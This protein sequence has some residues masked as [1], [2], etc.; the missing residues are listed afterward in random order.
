M[1]EDDTQTS[2]EDSVI[3]AAISEIVLDLDLTRTREWEMGP[4][5]ADTALAYWPDETASLLSNDTGTTV[6]ETE[7]SEEET[8]ASIIAE[9][10]T[11][12]LRWENSFLDLDSREEC[13]ES[14]ESESPSAI[15]FAPNV[16]RTVTTG[17]RYD[18]DGNLIEEGDN[19][20]NGALLD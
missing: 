10:E 19:T 6:F 5:R 2:S 4:A 14:W 7:D 12:E 3:S 20:V 18:V 17:P 15:V 9:L 13:R 1:Y 11:L 8:L 16:A